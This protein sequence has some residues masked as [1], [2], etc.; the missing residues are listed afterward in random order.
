MRI[1]AFLHLL[2][3]PLSARVGEKY[4]DFVKRVGKAEKVEPAAK[5]PVIRYYHTFNGITITAVVDGGIIRIEDYSPVSSAQADALVSRQKE[6]RFEKV[7]EG[8]GVVEWLTPE[9]DSAHYSIESKKLSVMDIYV[10]QV[11]IPK[12]LEDSKSEEIK[13]L[14]GL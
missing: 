7:R 13:K 14:D 8:R 6:G 3:L 2:L 10:S 1:L 5:G 9:K 4:E 11:A 12:V